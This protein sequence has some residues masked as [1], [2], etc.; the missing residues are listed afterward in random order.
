MSLEESMAKL[1]EA[2]L[3]FAAALEKAAERYDA[4]IEL[5]STGDAP[6]K[7]PAKEEAKPA[8]TRGRPAGAKNKPKEEPPADDGL[9]G[10]EEEETGSSVTFNEMKAKLVELREL[11]DKDAPRALMKKFGATNVGEIKEEDFQAVY[12]AAVKGIKAAK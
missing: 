9:G 10:D 5:Y 7:P 3:V 4:L 8:S 12:D 1:A 6:A 2:Q 11:T